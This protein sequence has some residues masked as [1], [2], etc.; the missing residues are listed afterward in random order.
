MTT[1]E[2]SNLSFGYS[3]KMV[4]E[5]INL[6]IDQP[7]LYCILGP[8]GVGKS[9]LIK[10]LNKINKPST[11]T[12]SIDGQDLKGM[13]SKEI[14]KYIGYV[15]VGGNDMFSMPVIDAILIGRYTQQKW[16]TTAEDISI[17]NRTMRLLGISSLALHGYNE[18]S[19]GQHQKV[20]IARGLVQEAPI[21]LLDEPT[22]NL[23]VR[24]QVYIAEL[25]KG[26]TRK[27]G[28]TVVMISHDLNITAKY[29]DQIIMMAPPG[30]IHKVGTPE[31]VITKETINE[32][33]GVNCEVLTDS[34]GKPHVILGSAL[35]IDE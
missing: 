17:V 27:T 11:G 31:E 14:S 2:V 28:M 21:L 25:L 23:D 9:T 6:K 15:P 1:I 4:I 12:V 5:D 10:C 29:A 8:N 26:L 3:Q 13:S 7:G 32:I 24:Y 18:L 34:E 19:A 22:A 30:R 20:A 33:Y 16:K 35:W